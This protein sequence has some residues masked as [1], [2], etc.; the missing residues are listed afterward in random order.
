[1]RIRCMIGRQPSK[2]TSLMLLTLRSTVL[3]E[4]HYVCMKA[5]NKKGDEVLINKINGEAGWFCL[6]NIHLCFALQLGTFIL[7]NG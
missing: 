1:M 2:Q 6:K 7:S 4:P 3:D 5:L